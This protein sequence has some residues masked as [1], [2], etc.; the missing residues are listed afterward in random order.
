MRINKLS[1]WSAD[2]IQDNIFHSRFSLAPPPGHAL[3]SCSR[4]RTGCVCVMLCVR[5]KGV[6]VCGGGAVWRGV[7][8]RSLGSL[9]TTPRGEEVTGPGGQSPVT[10][11]TLL[12]PAW[13]EGH[14]NT[15][16]LLPRLTSCQT[17]HRS[18]ESVL[19]PITILCCFSNCNICPITATK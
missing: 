7:L 9:P 1:A 5:R 18:A 4:F 16:L 15:P 11:N 3:L 12:T 8:L 17:T 2:I 10:S 19:K 13:K 14:H 6:C